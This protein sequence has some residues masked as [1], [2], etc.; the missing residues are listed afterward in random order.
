MK[1]K[2][3]RILLSTVHIINKFRGSGEVFVQERP[4]QYK[5]CSQGAPREKKNI[6]VGDF[7]AWAQKNFKKKK[8]RL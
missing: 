3:W 2:K 1:K 4:Y 6:T 5:S 8:K 7:T